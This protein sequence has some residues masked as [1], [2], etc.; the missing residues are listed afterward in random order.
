MLLANRL[1]TL[2]E[3]MPTSTEKRRRNRWSIGASGRSK[4]WRLLEKNGP[5]YFMSER[6]D[7]QYDCSESQ[8]ALRQ[9]TFIQF[10]EMQVA[11]RSW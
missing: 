1:D 8:E 3:Y 4:G 2:H 10:N 7:F 11:L 9:P 6:F 5:T